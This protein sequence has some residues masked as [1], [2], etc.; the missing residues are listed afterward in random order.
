MI[1]DRQKLS[2]TLLDQTLTSWTKPVSHNFISMHLSLILAVGKGMAPVWSL[3][4]FLFSSHSEIVSKHSNAALQTY[5]TLW[6]TQNWQV[7]TQ[8][9]LLLNQSVC[10]FFSG[11]RLQ[12][13]RIGWTQEWTQSG[14]DGDIKSLT[15]LLIFFLLFHTCIII[16]LLQSVYPD[17]DRHLIK[18][19]DLFQ[20][21]WYS[22]CVSMS[23]TRCPCVY[24]MVA[25]LPTA[26]LRY[27]K[28][29]ENLQ[30]MD[31]ALNQCCI[32]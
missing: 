7:F 6:S 14:W 15:G 30:L 22:M 11:F 21:W 27:L 18:D 3:L 26:F 23:E 20:V 1:Q 17:G 32:A 16:L 12:S 28:E 25:F 2:V 4:I 31:S 5:I 13:M 29:R 24:G 8:L 19:S 9:K 10:I